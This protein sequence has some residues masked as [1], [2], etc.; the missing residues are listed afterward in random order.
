M[1]ARVF[2]LQMKLRCEQMKSEHDGRTIEKLQKSCFQ[3]DMEIQELHRK[4]AEMEATIQAMHEALDH[5]DR[6]VEDAQLVNESYQKRFVELHAKL[7][8]CQE[9]ATPRYSRQTIADHG[10]VGDVP[11][12]TGLHAK[13][14]GLQHGFDFHL[15]PT[16]R[17]SITPSQ[18]D[19]P[20]S[21][22]GT[23]S[24]EETDLELPNFSGRSSH[25]T[26]LDLPSE[27]DLTSL[28]GQ[29]DGESVLPPSLTGQESP[30]RT[31]DEIKRQTETRASYFKDALERLDKFETVAQRTLSPIR[32]VG[33]EQCQLS[34]FSHTSAR[35]GSHSDFY[36]Q[37]PRS[38][39][40]FEMVKAWRP[41]ASAG[42]MGQNIDAMSPATVA[43]ASE[44]R[45]HLVPSPPSSVSDIW[46]EQARSGTSRSTSKSTSRYHRQ[47]SHFPRSRR[48]S[49]S[50]TKDSH[51]SEEPGAEPEVPIPRMGVGAILISMQQR[52]ETAPEHKA[53]VNTNVSGVS[54]LERADSLPSKIAAGFANG[55][56]KSAKK[57]GL[58]GTKKPKAAM[59]RANSSV[60]VA[61]RSV[62]DRRLLPPPALPFPVLVE[63]SSWETLRDMIDEKGFLKTT[64]AAKNKMKKTGKGLGDARK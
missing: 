50:E 13:T 41:N 22:P 26:S 1:A 8:Q 16:G 32:G 49:T 44:R 52:C 36:Q 9:E 47:S 24:E 19:V 46:V 61:G 59:Q 48:N 55:V 63:K 6:V 30:P 34:R 11:N 4:I 29:G 33:E 58:G 27:E 21:P 10:H 5:Q 20:R 43:K 57:L 25:C 14:T 18:Q 35:S 37:G 7:E 56:A 23:I 2:D 62:G 39:F 40:S 31:L 64:I 3:K 54:G 45:T 17:H 38:D 28:Y 51:H 42:A 15:T 12:T 53:E 60:L